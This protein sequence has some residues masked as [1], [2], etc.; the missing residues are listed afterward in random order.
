M[1]APETVRKRHASASAILCG[2]FPAPSSA[3]K[4]PKAIGLSAPRC[5]CCITCRRVRFSGP[6]LVTRPIEARW[7][8]RLGCDEKT[9]NQ[10]PSGSR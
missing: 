4:R 8:R 2:T 10:K 9:K 6:A 5:R 1:A 7:K 3:E